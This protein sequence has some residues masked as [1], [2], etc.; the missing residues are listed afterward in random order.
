MK[1]T[2]PVMKEKILEVWVQPRASR[3][4]IVGYRDQFLHLRVTAPPV[5]GEANQ[6]VIK[7][8]A[9]ALG[10]PP[11]R[12]EILKGGRGRRKKVRVLEVPLRNWEKLEN[13]KREAPKSQKPGEA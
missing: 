4:E 7:L 1:E 10:I 9:Q 11:S 2:F 3:S 12:V 13:M 8:I 5:E 6:S